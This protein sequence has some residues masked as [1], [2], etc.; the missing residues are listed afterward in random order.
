MTGIFTETSD[1]DVCLILPDLSE[2]EVINKLSSHFK[3][4]KIRTVKPILHA[5][6][7][8]LKCFAPCR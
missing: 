1:I 5:R 3:K 7:P 2:V 6:V 8:I 4:R